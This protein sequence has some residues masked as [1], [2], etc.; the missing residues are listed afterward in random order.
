MITTEEKIILAAINCIEKYGLENT[1]IRKIGEEA[2]TNSAS[3]SYYF[4][5]KDIFEYSGMNY[6][7]CP[8][9]G[10]RNSVQPETAVPVMGTRWISCLA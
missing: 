7:G 8:V 2:G 1:T 9:P 6:T 10:N 4:R 5:S 3:I